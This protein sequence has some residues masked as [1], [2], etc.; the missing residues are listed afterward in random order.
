MTCYYAFVFSPA[1]NRDHLVHYGRVLVITKTKT[2][3][4]HPDLWE[5]IDNPR[6]WEEKYVDN[7]LLELLANQAKDDLSR[8]CPE[9]ISFPFVKE[10]FGHHL[11][12]E[13][14]NNGE[15]SGAVHADKRISGG[16]RLLK[17]IKAF[18]LLKK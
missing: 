14:E 17:K 8:P 15:W 7:A 18:F 4:V 10:V 1:E 6:D 9:V 5:I 3:K 2:N 11:I 16:Y 12:E 13:M